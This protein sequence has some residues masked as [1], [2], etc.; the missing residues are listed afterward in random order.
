MT[1]DQWE[2]LRPSAKAAVFTKLD[3]RLSQGALYEYRPYPKQ[4]EFHTAGAEYPERLLMAAN[5]VGKTLCGGMENAYH[6]TGE[7]PKWWKGKVFDKAPRMWAASETSEMTVAGVQASLMGRMETG[8]G[9]GAI[10]KA[11]IHEHRKKAHGVTGALE[12]VI[13]RHGGG[14]DV[15]AGFGYCGFKS[16]DQGREKFQAETLEIVWFDEEPPDDVYFEGLTRIS[17]TGGMVMTTFTPLKGATRVVVRFIKERP[18]GTNVTS[19]TI[20]D[21]G[22][23]SKAERDKIIAR[24]PAHEREARTKGIPKMG[25]GAVYP[26]EEATIAVKRFQIPN[27]FVRIGGL[28]FG[29]EH[30]TGAVGLAWDRDNNDFYVHRAHRLKHAT[31]VVFAGSVRDWDLDWLPW[32][33]PHD[34]KSEAGGKYGMQDVKMLAQLYADQGMKMLAEHATFEDGSN[35]VEPGVMGI[36][37]LM[38]TGH[39]K[40][41]DDLTS[42]WEEFR[43]YH[44]KEG[45][46]VKTDDDI[47]CAMRYAWMM[48]RFAVAP[49]RAKRIGNARERSWKTV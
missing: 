36:L 43:M 5:R 9:T 4:I 27:H 3:T 23:F 25:S 33:W 29:W 26:V 22:H 16:Y 35:G 38:Q 48:I 32:A 31:P 12:Y 17:T 40:V 42:W 8:F 20:L 39:F 44:R 18:A 10:P 6:L 45:V 1:K 21:A 7:Y 2:S 30:P 34:G 15:Q 46:I 11:R 37:D 41:F 14:G 13:V 19:M 24:Y 28:D 47:M 49:P